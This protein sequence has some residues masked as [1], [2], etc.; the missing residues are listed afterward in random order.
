MNAVA[1]HMAASVR[2]VTE[3]RVDRLLRQDSTWSV[4]GIQDQDL[5]TFDAVVLALPAGQSVD[6]LAGIP[7]LAEKA[8]QS[9]FAPCWAVMAGF[10]RRLDITFDAAF[11]H[12]SPLSWIARNSSKP[13]RPAAECWVLHASPSWSTQHFD[14][15][16]EDVFAGLAGEFRRVV[17]LP[18]CQPVHLVAHRW[19][20]ALPTD[21]L[22]STCLWDA[23]ARIAVAGD[24]CNGS[25][26]EGAF[27]S[28][29]SAAERVLEWRGESATQP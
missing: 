21:P 8:A 3:S 5:G 13:G 10:E 29:L 7:A 11:V 16:P 22:T 18:G 28:G 23:A 24:W 12:N 4:R 20:Y 25:R 2:V 14:D 17:G 26:I 1:K 19:R 15:S 6:L 27:L 9:T